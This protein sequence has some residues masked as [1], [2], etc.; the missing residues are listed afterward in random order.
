MASKKEELQ[1]KI[2]AQE[3]LKATFVK[4]GNKKFADKVED[5]I[6]A[7]KEK[8]KELNAEAKKSEAKPKPKKSKVIASGMTREACIEFL[9]SKSNTYMKS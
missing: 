4:K 7:A 1:K 6:K 2:K 9:K 3:A 8:L 5:K